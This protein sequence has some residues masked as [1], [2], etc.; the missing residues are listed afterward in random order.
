MIY[1]E[2]WVEIICMDAVDKEF[3]EL[4]DKQEVKQYVAMLMQCG[5]G[6]LAALQTAMA[7][8]LKEELGIPLRWGMGLL[9]VLN[10]LPLISHRILK[11]PP[12][13]SCG[14]GF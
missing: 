10:L 1:A 7:R 3:G 12:P 8:E 2:Q 11:W 4:A 13:S 5:Y 6:T 14:G 9:R